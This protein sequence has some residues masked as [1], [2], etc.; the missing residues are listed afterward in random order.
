MSE[1]KPLS[2][3]LYNPYSLPHIYFLDNQNQSNTLSIP[4]KENNILNKDLNLISDVD[5]EPQMNDPIT[6]FIIISIYGIILLPSVILIQ[7]RTLKMLKSDN[8]ID[9]R[10][11]K[12]QARLH[13]IFWPSAIF[14]HALVDN[15]YPLSALTSTYFCTTMNMYITFAMISMILYSLY[16]AILRYLYLV[17]E[18]IVAKF[19]KTKTISVVFWVYYLHTI[20]WSLY[21]LLTGHYAF[22]YPWISSCYG[23]KD[24]VF[25]LEVSSSDVLL[26]QL[27]VLVTGSGKIWITCLPWIIRYQLYQMTLVSLFLFRRHW[28]IWNSA[29]H[30]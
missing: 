27:G 24:R 13:M 2:T 10:M 30:C 28:C 23:W 29:T 17:Q 8:S 26:R 5:I 22:T 18:K 25:L 3:Y 19:G 7:T 11:M 14:L 12:S 4:E 15:I 9:T 16:A 21:I 20:I 1:L 6:S